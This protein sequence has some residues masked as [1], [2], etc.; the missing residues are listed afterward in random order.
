MESQGKPQAKEFKK[1]QNPHTKLNLKAQGKKENLKSANNQPNANQNAE[2]QKQIVVINN[3]KEYFI[4][5]PNKSFIN[6]ID[7]I[8]IIYLA[9]SRIRL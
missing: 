3:E 7:I 4:F 6:L 1:I 5:N 8:I 2:T 9:N